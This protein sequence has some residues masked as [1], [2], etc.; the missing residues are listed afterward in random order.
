MAQEFLFAVIIVGAIFLIVAVAEFFVLHKNRKLEKDLV[1]REEETKSKLYEMEILRELG[2]KMGYSL[3]VQTVVE[4]I[5]KSLHDIVDYT[6]VSYMMILPEKIIFRSYVEKP[7]FRNFINGVK[8]KM[9]DS[10]SAILKTDIKNMAVE[11]T[12]WGTVTEEKSDQQVGSFFNIPLIIS[13]KVAGILSISDI[14]PGFFNEEEM[15]AVESATKQ[16]TDAVTRLQGVVEAEKSKLNAMVASMT[17]GVVMTDTD[18]QVL[19][20]NPTAKRAMG[21]EDRQDLSLSDFAGGLNG[22]IDLHDKIE[23]SIRLD[24]IFF[25]EE[26]SLPSGF[27]KIAI[28]PVKDSW[29]TLG[30]VVVFHDMTREKEVERI[31]EDFTS[32]IVHELRSPLDSIKKI[33]ELLRASA[34]KK[35]KQAEYLQMVYGSS[36]DMLELINNLLDIAKIE[37]GKFALTKKPSDIKQI[38]K[39][40]VLFFD[41]AAK[42]ANVKISSQLGK[43]VPDKVEFDP[44]TV[45]QVLN[46]LI[47]N[48]IK[49]NKQ[50]GFVVVQALLH[51]NGASLEREAIDAGISWYIKNDIADI[52]DSLL[53]AVTNSGAGIAPDQM[54][55][56]FNKFSQVR[57][58]FTE[59]GGTGLGLAITKSIIESHGGTVGAKSA[60]GQG[61]TFYFTLPINI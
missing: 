60:E 58:V 11:E 28:S 57:T 52:K 51:K 47:S 33:V 49:F 19:V 25:S 8:E 32:M 15:N 17:E 10:A 37:A 29:R 34:I 50:D 2:D 30:C 21:F 23:E 24:K 22:K 3:N 54:D 39:E 61:A 42:D 9:L 53:V 38:I 14:K 6:V 1:R 5:I 20:V 40:R 56:L 36:S 31:K 13:G 44:H 27:F 12:L 43:D 4:V 59:K 16:V 45:S 55:K 41:I 46:N 26:I 7:V 18:Y 35:A 48:A